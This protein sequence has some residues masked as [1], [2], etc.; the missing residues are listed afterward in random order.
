MRLHIFLILLFALFIFSCGQDPIFYN[1]SLDEKPKDPRIAGNPTNMVIVGERMYVGTRHGRRIHYFSKTGWHTISNP[2]GSLGDLATDGTDLYALVFPKGEPTTSSAI[3]K[4]DVSAE[5]WD[6]GYISVDPS[7]SGYKIQNIFGAGGKI[8]A[9]AMKE[10]TYAVLCYEPGDSLTV[11]KDDKDTKILSGAAESGGDIYLAVSGSGVYKFPDMDTKIPDV[12]G[13]IVGIITT[14]AIVTAVSKDGNIYTIAAGGTT[15]NLI[16]PKVRALS[17]ALCVWYEQ[18]DSSNT[19]PS[20]WTPSLLLLGINGAHG[21]LELEL[22]GGIPTLDSTIKSPG[23][24]KLPTSAENKRAKYEASIG[25]KPVEGL[26]H[27]VELF[28]SAVS[29]K[30]IPVF[31][32][33]HQDGIWSCWAGTWNAE[34]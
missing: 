12:S 15:V 28:T 33:T 23:N 3:K 22:V 21:Y 7:A 8:F 11:I 19:D 13:N 20:S 18:P 6:A 32:A 30:D 24:E 5:K 17:G 2:G 26:I 4:Y 27:P 34:D 31:A 10:S 16:K 9:G 1:I 25:K 29:Q 14:G